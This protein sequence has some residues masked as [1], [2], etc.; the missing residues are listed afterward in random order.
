MQALAFSGGLARF[1]K[2]KDI[3]ILRTVNGQQTK[4]PFNY[5]QVVKG[6]RINQNIMLM[7]GDII[8]VP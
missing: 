2:E 8:V 4:I 7:D 3:I 1:A 6:K 5:D